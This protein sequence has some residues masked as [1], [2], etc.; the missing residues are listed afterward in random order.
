M[1]LEQLIRGQNLLL[2]TSSFP[3]AGPE[4]TTTCLHSHRSPDGASSR[5]SPLPRSPPARPAARARAAE[6]PCSSTSANPR[7]SPT[8]ATWSRSTTPPRTTSRSSSTTSSNLQ[9]GFLRGNPPD[10]GLLNYNMEMARF[11]ARGAL[12]DLK[13]M[14]EAG[15]ILPEVQQLVNQLAAYPGPHQRA[16]LLGDGRLGHLQQADLRRQRRRGARDLGRLPRRL[17]H[18][19]G[20]RHRPDLLDVQGR[21]DRLAGPVRLHRR[22]H[23]RR[24]RLLQ[25]AAQGGHQR[26]AELERLVR[27]DPHRAGEP[28]GDARA[29]VHQQGCREPRVRRRQP[30]LQQGRGRDV[31]PGP[32]GLRRDRQERP[33]PRPGHLPAADDRRPAASARCG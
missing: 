5:G 33:R 13:D 10:L 32:V 15:R 16:A 2:V 6:N 19:R 11:M 18:A 3:T 29:E 23:G 12:S 1:Q 9:A 26:R 8:S 14:P 24:R 28:D 20:R 30:R 25:P 7:P 21:L 27:E 17:R 31:L 22:R 4:R